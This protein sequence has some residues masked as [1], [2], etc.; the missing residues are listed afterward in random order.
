MRKE[1]AWNWIPGLERI[2]RKIENSRAVEQQT[3]VS[4]FLLINCSFAQL[5]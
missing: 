4:L 3:A 1:K 5:L 2:N